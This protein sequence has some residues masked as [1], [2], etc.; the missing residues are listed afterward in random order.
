MRPPAADEYPPFYETY[1]RLVPAGDVLSCLS[2]APAA[3]DALLSGVDSQQSRTGYAPGK[4]TFREVVGH[5][6]DAERMFSYRALHMAR[7]D[8]AELPGMEQDDWAAC[9][10]A[11]ERELASLLAEFRAL[12]NANVHLFSSFDEMT[13]DRRGIASGGGF[14]VRALVH[15]VAGHELHHR[16]VLRERYLG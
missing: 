12:R 8:R 15:I 7:G 6:N 5:V 11:K 4:W 10:N 2:S 3:L 16:T 9:S 13:L 14:T 1:V